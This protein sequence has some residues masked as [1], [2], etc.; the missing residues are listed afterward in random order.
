MHRTFMLKTPHMRGDDVAEFQDD[1][2]ARYAAWHINKQIV[3]DDDYG[4]ATH[5]AAV[6]VCTCLGIDAKTAMQH[7][8]DPD[9]RI[10]IRHPDK[11]TPH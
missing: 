10:K 5:D 11:R 7:G 3:K 9:L 6:E 1:L 4:Q 8:V 2:N